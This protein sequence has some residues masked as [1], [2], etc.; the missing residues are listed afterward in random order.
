MF[1]G[2]KSGTSST[3][4]DC[5]FK[6]SSSFNS[7]GEFLPPLPV[8][9]LFPGVLGSGRLDSA[10]LPPN[11]VEVMGMVFHHPHETVEP[12]EWEGRLL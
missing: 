8:V 9:L 4:V 2:E 12:R 7:R 5:S 10:V 3:H 1:S 11:Q 6:N